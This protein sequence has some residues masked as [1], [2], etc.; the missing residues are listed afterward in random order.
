MCSSPQ[1][2]LLQLVGWLAYVSLRE[3]A[4]AWPLGAVKCLLVLTRLAVVQLVGAA[5]LLVVEHDGEKAKID[6]WA[7]GL[8]MR[9]K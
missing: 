7:D 3:Q 4:T 9:G 6:R 1:I 8:R 5:V 2:L